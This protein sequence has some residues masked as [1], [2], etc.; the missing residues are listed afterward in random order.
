MRSSRILVYLT[1]K[2]EKD[3]K[4][5]SSAQRR[6]IFAKLE[7]ADFSPNAPHVKKLAATKGCEPEIFRA[8]IGTYRL[9]YI[10]E[11]EDVI[12]LRIVHRKDLE[13]A[14]RELL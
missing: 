3:L 5:L 6:R 14:I 10:L 9:L 2:A 4:T 11:G 1:A 12:I 7:K 13:K 8:R